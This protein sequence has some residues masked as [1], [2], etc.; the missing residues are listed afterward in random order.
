MNKKIIVGLGVT[1]LLASSLMAFNCQSP[2]KHGFFNEGYSQ[3]KMMK[4]NKH[5]RGHVF[6]KTVMRLN[7][8]DEQRTKVK[9]IL[10]KNFEKRPNPH[11][12][13][14]DTSFDKKEFIRLA[15]E[16]RDGKIEARA[17][18][19]DEIYTLLDASQKKDLKTMLDMR[20]IM[21]KNRGQGKQCNGKGN[22]PR[23]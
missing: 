18:M 1:A 8:S 4:R 6:V 15:K 10:K 21:K 3:H 16:R 12:A 19:M 23:R 17:E 9:A 14:T 20:D 11:D 22:H 5:K 13:F 7:L 2:M